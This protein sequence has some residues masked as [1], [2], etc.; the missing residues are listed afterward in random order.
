MGN[1]ATT[2]RITVFC[3]D[4]GRSVIKSTARHNLGLAV[5]SVYLREDNKGSRWLHTQRRREHFWDSRC[6][7]WEKPGWPED[8]KVCAQVMTL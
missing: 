5:A 6:V 7:V 1:G 3:L 8:S 4:N 2:T